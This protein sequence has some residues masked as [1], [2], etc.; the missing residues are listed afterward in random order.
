MNKF[1]YIILRFSGLPLLFRELIQKKRVTI[2]LFHNITVK[3]A[4]K[5]FLYLSKKYNIIDLND[6]I[7]ACAQKDTS[8]IPTKAMIITLDDGY[9]ENH[10]LL[11]LLKKLNMPVTIFLCAALVNTNRHFWFWFKNPFFSVEELKHK[12]NNERLLLLSEAGF[13]QEMEFDTPA[14]LSKTQIEEMKDLV[15]FQSHTLFHQILPRGNDREARVEIF[16]SKKI[17]EQE[18]NLKINAISYPNGDYSERD[19]ALCKEAGYQCGITVDY[20]F[21]TIDTNPFRL[22]RLYVN[23]SSDINELIIKASGIGAFLRTRNGRQ[24]SYGFHKKTHE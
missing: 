8:K 6:F 20:G 15:N 2:L 13:K 22:K 7:M 18:Y 14:A 9:I 5:T 17:L 4:E 16:D 24:Q 19:I 3:N 11:P 23:D 10:K 1:I 12:T 21:N